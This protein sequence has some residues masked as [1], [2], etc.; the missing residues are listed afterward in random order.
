MQTH[1]GLTRPKD[2][3][4]WLSFASKAA[5]AMALHK[6]AVHAH[7]MSSIV[8]VLCR[9]CYKNKACSVKVPACCVPGVA[10]IAAKVRSPSMM[11]A[12]ASTVPFSVRLEP[13][14][15]FVCSFP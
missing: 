6:P 15:A 14:P 4:C 2:S 9:C 1:M 7:M 3:G 8:T 12:S 5:V 11:L 10:P 13:M